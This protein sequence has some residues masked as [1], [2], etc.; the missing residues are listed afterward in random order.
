[1]SYR[2]NRIIRK[3]GAERLPLFGLMEVRSM[4]EQEVPE[5]GGGQE[6]DQHD[7]GH[8]IAHHHAIQL[9]PAEM[10][11]VFLHLIDDPL[12]SAGH[13]VSAKNSSIKTIGET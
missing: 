10:L 2:I 7:H 4:P 1:M 8:H 9:G 12:G 6:Q 3:A 5:A 13:A 11:A